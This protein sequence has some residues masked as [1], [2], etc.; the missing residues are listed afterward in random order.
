MLQLLNGIYERTARRCMSADAGGLRFESRSVII[1]AAATD[2][3]AHNTSARGAAPPAPLPT[4]MRQVLDAHHEADGV[5]D[6]G[7]ATAIEAR[8]GI[9][10]GIEVGER[11][12]LGIGFEP[13]D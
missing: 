9:E 12:T 11:H 3:A 4:H 1:N 2:A 7:L 13:I 8:D 5:Q 10:A 6:V